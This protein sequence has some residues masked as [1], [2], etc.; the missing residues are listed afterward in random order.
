MVVGDKDTLLFI[1]V[2]AKRSWNR[3]E[4]WKIAMFAW[5]S[6]VWKVTN[7]LTFLVLQAMRIA[8]IPFSWWLA[9]F[10]RGMFSSMC[11]SLLCFRLS[12]QGI[13]HEKVIVALICI[14]I[15]PHRIKQAHSDHSQLINWVYEFIKMCLARLASCLFCMRERNQPWTKNPFSESEFNKIKIWRRTSAVSLVVLRIFILWAYMKTKKRKVFMQ[16]GFVSI[17]FMLRIAPFFE[18]IFSF[19]ALA[20]WLHRTNGYLKPK[21]P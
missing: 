16:R 20:R 13:F 7:T 19:M 5:R 12:R 18:F 4:L 11:F 15:I 21:L 14:S 10:P 9:E 17:W 6:V 8:R 2:I 3:A 1:F